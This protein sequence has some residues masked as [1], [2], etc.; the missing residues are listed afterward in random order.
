MFKKIFI[1]ILISTNAIPTIFAQNFGIS[2]QNTIWKGSMLTDNSRNKKKNSIILSLNYYYNLSEKLDV[3][4]SAGYAFGFEITPL[5]V[6][7]NYKISDKI[8][9][10]LGMG[11]YIIYDDTYDARGQLVEDTE[12]R[13]EPS[14]SESGINFGMSY[15]LTSNIALTGNYN[16]LKND[17]ADFNGI[18][19]GLSFTP[20]WG[21]TIKQQ[22]QWMRV[23]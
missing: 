4:G 15:K 13:T 6:N 7:F 14:K 12:K 8:S 19:F 3:V 20:F 21:A 17:E 2:L 18:S 9:A 11:I 22:N 5:K 23:G 16:I 10:N 1:I